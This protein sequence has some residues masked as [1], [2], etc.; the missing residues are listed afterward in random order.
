MTAAGDLPV[1]PA[2]WG[3]PSAGWHVDSYGPDHVVS[4]SVFVDRLNLRNSV[5]YDCGPSSQANHEDDSDRRD[6]QE[7]TG[8]H[9]DKNGPHSST[10]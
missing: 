8:N 1:P 7:E 3:V 10:T 2:R 4:G 5:D 9:S 6:E